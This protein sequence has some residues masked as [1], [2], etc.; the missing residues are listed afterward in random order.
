ML[1]NQ[2]RIR[3]THTYLDV[4]PAGSQ[5]QITLTDLPRHL[6]RLVEIGFSSDLN[7]GERVLP[8][9]TKSVSRFNANGS[10]KILRHLPKETVYREGSVKDWHGNWHYVDIP[11]ERYPREPIPAPGEELTIVLNG[12]SKVISSRVFSYNSQDSSLMNQ[13]KH[14]INLFLELF[15]ECWIQSDMLISLEKFKIERRNWRILP[16]GEYPWEKV[17]DVLVTVTRSLSESRRHIV[18]YRFKHIT[19]Y[20][21]T[22]LII[23]EA[24]FDGYVIFCFEQD[25][26]NKIYLL[27]SRFTDNATYVFGDNWESLSK[28]TKSEIIN[29]DLHLE[30]FVHSNG[31]SVKIDQLF[32]GRSGGTN[33]VTSAV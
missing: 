25:S 4:L 5:F 18:E 3:N 20:N 21:P 14:V 16:F 9:P 31:W 22:K 28:L 15:G 27:E 12:E 13:I 1:I 33:L 17:K 11:Y 30:R 23:G 24:G 6:S 26:E 19:L 10:W 7:V 8:K 2:R 29:G 32:K